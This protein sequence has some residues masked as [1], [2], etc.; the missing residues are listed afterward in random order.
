MFSELQNKKVVILGFGR[1][2]QATCQ[3]LLD[4]KI[5]K[6]KNLFVSDERYLLQYDKKEQAFIKKLEKKG[7][8]FFLGD[9]WK[10]GVRISE[11]IIKSPGFAVSKIGSYKKSKIVTSQTE[12]FFYNFPGKVIGITGTKG[13]ST[14]TA[15]VYHALQS[16]KNVRLAGNIGIPM[17]LVLPKAT[18]KT[19]AILELSCHQLDGLK[20]SPNISVFLNIFP[21]HLD[22]YSDCDRYFE[23]KSSIA[24]FQKESDFFIYN[25]NFEK[26]A[27]LAEKSS[28][29]KIDFSNIDLAFLNNQK[30]SLDLQ[31]YADNIK[32]VIAICQILKVKE[33]KIL[34]ALK[35][36]KPLPHRLEFVGNYKKIDFYNDSLA[37]VPQA[38]MAAIQSFHGRVNS[39]IL[40][41]YDRNINNYAD[42]AETIVKSKIENIAFF[43]DSGKK[44]ALAISEYCE[45]SRLKTPNYF[46]ASSMPEAVDFC[47]RL[48]K[49]NTIC[50]LSC[51]APSFGLFKDYKDRGDQFKKYIKLKK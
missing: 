9:L 3:Y 8:V 37:T 10:D 14:T 41:G 22:Y 33:N 40:G 50:L 36:F 45:K 27:R 31:V 21:E 16:N 12:L 35:T 26:I 6:A 23:A 44:M 7:V 46:F 24:L 32:A 5:V 11:I 1:E 34:N 19:I 29:Q 51:A 17:F 47:F 42:L 18:S 13:K 30:I 25:G 4:K 48:T 2:G 49:P 20:I 38:T 28:A 15:L 39:I 43:P